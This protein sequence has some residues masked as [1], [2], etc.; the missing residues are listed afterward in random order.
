MM[1]ATLALNIK[2]LTHANSHHQST[3]LYHTHRGL[4]LTHEKENV[5]LMPARCSSR[6]MFFGGGYKQRSSA[7]P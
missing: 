3:Q 7:L 5:C 2:T 4:G 6:G 1:M